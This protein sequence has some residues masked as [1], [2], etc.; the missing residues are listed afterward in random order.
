MKRMYRHVSSYAPGGVLATMR[1][2]C[3]SSVFS[4][5]TGSPDA[6]GGAVVVMELAAVMAAS[7]AAYTQRRGFRKELFEGPLD[8]KP[9]ERRARKGPPVAHSLPVYK[10]AHKLNNSVRWKNA[11]LITNVAGGKDYRLRETQGEGTFDESG[12]Y[13]DWLYGDERRYANY[14]GVALGCLSIGLFLYTMRVMGAETWDIPA[15]VLASQRKKTAAAKA[16]SE[17]AATAGN[18]KGAEGRSGDDAA[19]VPDALAMLKKPVIVSK[20]A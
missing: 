8:I 2:P 16:A 19:Q 7:S 5:T 15:P 3:R 12:M 4:L 13:R 9:G 17:G 1:R 11:N 14:I 18:E 6:G 10:T 20:A